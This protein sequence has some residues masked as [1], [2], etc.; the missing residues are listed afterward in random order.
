MKTDLDHLIIYYFYSGL[1]ISDI[2][3]NMK[4]TICSHVKDCN[5]LSDVKNYVT[6]VIYNHQIS[7]KGIK[8]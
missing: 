4:N 2:S 8:K 7:Q 5:K 3:R 1:S 6:R